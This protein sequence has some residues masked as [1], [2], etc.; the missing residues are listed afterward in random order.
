MN[1]L[2]PAYELNKVCKPLFIDSTCHQY[3][4]PQGADKHRIN[5]I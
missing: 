1:N 4:L 2:L 3:A 5:H